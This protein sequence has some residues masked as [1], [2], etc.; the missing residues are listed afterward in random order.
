MKLLE[1]N[2]KCRQRLPLH[3][4]VVAWVKVLDGWGY[5][6]LLPSS[7]STSPLFFG[8]TLATLVENSQIVFSLNFVP[9]L[10]AHLYYT[11]KYRGLGTTPNDNWPGADDGTDCCAT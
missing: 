8:S 7:S 5:A 10:R 3:L 2:F 4:E 11:K 9:D 1:K 6:I